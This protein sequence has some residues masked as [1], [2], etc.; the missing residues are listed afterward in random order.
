MK[1]YQLQNERGEIFRCGS[2]VVV[3]DGN[4]KETLFS[5]GTEIMSRNADG[6]MTRAWP[7]W[8]RTTGKHIKAFCGLNKAGF[9][10]LKFN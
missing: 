3:V 4:G 2:P 5:Y 1:L 9:D 7:G 8:T 10:N 6:V